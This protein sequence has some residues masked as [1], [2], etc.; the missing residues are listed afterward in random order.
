MMHGPI[1]LRI[2]LPIILYR[3]ETWSLKLKKERRLRV[4]EEN[5]L[6]L[7]GRGNGGI[8]KTR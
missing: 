4:F 7:D 1:Y 6:T 5:I 8:E 3:C 2:I